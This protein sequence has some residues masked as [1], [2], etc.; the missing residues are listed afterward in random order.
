[1]ADQLCGDAEEH[2]S[3]RERCCEHML[4][5]AE[6]WGFGWVGFVGCADEGWMIYCNSDLLQ[7]LGDILCINKV[8]RKFQNIFVTSSKIEI[9]LP[10]ETEY[11]CNYLGFKDILCSLPSFGRDALI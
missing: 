5:H 1:M 9:T 8:A 3:Y 10:L 2:Q 6:V 4:D 7:F 11:Y